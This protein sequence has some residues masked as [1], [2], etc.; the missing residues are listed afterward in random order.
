MND[1][2]QDIMTSLLNMRLKEIQKRK[3][4]LALLVEVVITLAV[5]YL[6][7]GVIFGISM[8]QGD[9]MEPSL[10]SGDIVLTY[11]L[12]KHYY[13][14]DIVL[15]KSD[16]NSDYIKR[17][18]GLP[19]QTVEIDADTFQ[20]VID[21]VTVAEPFIYEKTIPKTGCDYPVTLA[22]D[23]YFILGDHRENSVDSRNYGV[24][25]GKDLHGV[26]IAVLR[27]GS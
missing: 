10:H 12:R 7:F 14:N 16:G 3:A 24:V 23:E 6:L 11:R 22:K 13:T 15:A 25:K 2:P 8:V 5:I 19:Y 17:V 20:L 27:F 21:S 9:S 1:K 4:A 26:V 18:V